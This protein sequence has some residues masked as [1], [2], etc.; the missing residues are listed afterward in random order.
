MLSK[1]RKEQIF[2]IQMEKIL[3]TQKIFI[4][5]Q[6]LFLQLAHTF[7]AV[8]YAYDSRLVFVARHCLPQARALQ[9]SQ[10]QLG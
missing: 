6:Q 1:G 9:F 3:I 7:S 2:I 10:V 8:Q 5:R 4:L